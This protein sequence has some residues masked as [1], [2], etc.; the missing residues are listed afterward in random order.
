MVRKACFSYLIR[1]E[2]WTSKLRSSPHPQWKFLYYSDHIHGE[3]HYRSHKRKEDTVAYPV[4]PKSTVDFDFGDRDVK[5][6]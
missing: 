3:P 6:L 5:T 2:V 1:R 4:L